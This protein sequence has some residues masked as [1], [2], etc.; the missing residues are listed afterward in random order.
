MLPDREQHWLNLGADL[1]NE[2]ARASLLASGLQER[3]QV[4]I[5]LGS[6]PTASWL[7]STA[8][9][10]DPFAGSALQSRLL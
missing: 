9:A 6:A 5:D 1:T 3:E 4:G 8:A 7:R 2:H 10:K